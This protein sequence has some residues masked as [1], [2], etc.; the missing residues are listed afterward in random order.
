MLNKQ[1]RVLQVLGGL[2]PGGAET[3]IMNYYRHIDK[4]QIQFDFIIHSNRNDKQFYEDE[5]K[6]M[7]GNIFHLP[8][9]FVLNH[10][11]YKRKWKRFF[12]EH[13][14]Y[15]IIHGHMRSTA[16]IYLKIAKK[17]GLKTI[18]HSHS[19]DNGNGIKAVVRNFLCGKIVKYSDYFVACSN[20]AAVWLFGPSILNS[21]KYILLKNAIELSKYR[22]DPKIRKIVRKEL[23]INNEFVI[24]HVG[25]FCTQK[26]HEF[27]I[28]LFKKMN[29]DS[30]INLRLILVGTGELRDRIVEKSIDYKIIDKIIFLENRSDVNEILQAFDIFCFPSIHEGL[31][32]AA[33]EAQ[34]SGLPTIISN[35]VPSDTIVTKNVYKLPLDI[36][37]WEE[38]IRRIYSLQFERCFNYE[39]LRLAGYDINN[40]IKKLEKLYLNICNWG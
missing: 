19:M 16:S 32:I 3:M 34:A 40:E 27:L 38:N 8:K 31:G 25:R 28:D 30:N 9:Y 6:K 18:S 33:I 7:G 26:N 17:F 2:N 23:D 29:D 20:D 21:S 14:D 39:D 15:K 36:S 10:F 35:F 11:S 37:L 12:K 1:I 24:G 4:T 5:I 22:F 13:P